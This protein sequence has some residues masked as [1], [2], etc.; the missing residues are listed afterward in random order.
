[1]EPLSEADYAWAERLGISRARADWL[2]SCPSKTKWGKERKNPRPY[3]PNH[4]LQIVGGLVYFRCR[5]NG[6]D[7]IERLQ[8]TIEECRKRRDELLAHKKAAKTL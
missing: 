1:M 2:A 5:S 3:N 7:V 6:V 8:G 4:N